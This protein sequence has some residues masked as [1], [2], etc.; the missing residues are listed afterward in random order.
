MNAPFFPKE[1]LTH[2][3]DWEIILEKNM[4]I[5]YD[6]EKGV[7]K[8]DVVVWQRLSTWRG[9]ASWMGLKLK[10]KKKMLLE[11]DDNV[12]HV[13]SSNPGHMAIYP[14]S[15]AYEVFKK[16]L[17]ESDGVIVTTNNLKKYYKQFNKHIWVIPNSLDFNVWNTALKKKKAHKKVVIAWQGGTHHS[18][19]LQL[20]NSV[21]PKVLKEFGDNVEFQFYGYM[22]DTLKIKGCTFVTPTGVDKYIENMVRI[23]PDIIIAPLCDNY[24]NRGRS[25]LRVIEAGAMSVPVVVSAGKELPYQEVVSNSHGGY[26]A[27]NTA[28]WVSA[29]GILIKSPKLRK[30][31]GVLLNGYVKKNYDVHDTVRKYKEIIASL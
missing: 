11:I 9:F 25:N 12:F 4:D 29:L 28:D 2:L 22:P 10:H 18:L 16:Q 24:L 13:D 8:A 30:K 31:L 19:D 14:G 5:L 23:N 3:A 27:K 17:Q 26:L 21:V 20:L 6:I 7:E 1:S 15:E